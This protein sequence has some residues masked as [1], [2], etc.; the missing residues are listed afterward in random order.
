[1]VKI[2]YFL[3][4]GFEYAQNFIPQLVADGAVDTFETAFKSQLSELLSIILGRIKHYIL[5]GNDLTDFCDCIFAVDSSA[6]IPVHQN[7]IDFIS[8][9]IVFNRTDNVIH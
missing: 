6:Q 2:E 8:K 1:M 3:H 7:Q 5:I 4:E 9:D